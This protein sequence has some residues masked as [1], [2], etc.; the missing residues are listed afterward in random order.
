VPIRFL[1]NVNIIANYGIYSSS[2]L[3]NKDVP[4]MVIVCGVPAKILAE[5]KSTLNYIISQL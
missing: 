2:A 1:A 3:F 4:S 5:A